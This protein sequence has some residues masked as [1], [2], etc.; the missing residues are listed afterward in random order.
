[1]LLIAVLVIIFRAMVRYRKNIHFW[2][3]YIFLKKTSATL[4]AII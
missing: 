1:L 4:F 3:R 2:N